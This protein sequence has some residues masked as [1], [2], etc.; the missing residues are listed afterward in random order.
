MTLSKE[1]EQNETQENNSSDEP[2]LQPVNNDAV[3]YTLQNN[4]LHI[5]F[6]HGSDW[7]KV[8][9]EKDSLFS[10]EYTGNRQELI[11]GSYILTE[12]KVAFLYSDDTDET[13]KIV[14][15]YSN[16]QGETWQKG[17]VAESFPFMR[18]RKIAFLNNQ[19]GYVILSGDRTMSQEYSL[20][21]LTHDGGKTWEETSEP[22]NTRLLV[23]G[24]FV[25][26][27]T[28]FMSF[29]TI[30]P[31]EPDLYVTQDGGNTWSEAVIPIPKKYDKI[32]VQAE[33]PVKEG[34]HLA[35]LVNQGPQ[36]DYKGGKVK[37]KFISKDNG[38]MWDF[39]TEVQSMEVE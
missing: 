38:L 16:D 4:E 10:G 20:S 33:L 7:I 17:V 34:D 28:G 21:F 18:F 11:V 36:G 3:G 25:D 27:N 23:D 6:N 13:N 35:V 5:T 30:N 15:K 9:V 1:P 19:F 31:E 12:K 32:F 29:G 37:G 14:I 2:E 24:G 26:E 22:G 39:S 8:P